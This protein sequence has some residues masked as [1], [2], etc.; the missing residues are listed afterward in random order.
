MS[1]PAE[2]TPRIA[3]SENPEFNEYLDEANGP[4]VVQELT[5]APSEVLYK[6][7]YEAYLGCLLSI[8]RRRDGAIG[9][10][11]YLVIPN[12][13]C[14]QLPPVAKGLPERQPT[15]LLPRETHGRRSSTR[16]SR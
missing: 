8:S 9:T 11:R 12:P 4:V 16:S 2:D 7:D 13:S 6:T 3:Y 5:Y 14:P 15:G 1:Q 10:E